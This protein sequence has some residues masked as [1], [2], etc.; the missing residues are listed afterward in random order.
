[1]SRMM[2]LRNMTFPSIAFIKL[3]FKL[4]KNLSRMY[5]IH[6][7]PLTH[8]QRR[9]VQPRRPVNDATLFNLP[10]FL[11]SLFQ[12][13]R[14]HR[15]KQYRFNTL[16]ETRKVNLRPLSQLLNTVPS[17]LPS[18]K[19]TSHSN[20]AMLPSFLC[21]LLLPANMSHLKPYLDRSA[22]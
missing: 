13:S 3:Y 6:R 17:C 20:G 5:Q 14:S 22:K 7:N 9:M 12:S 11:K 15:L 4:R 19:V 21:L 18:Q 2:A 8:L 16:L 1:M 10:T